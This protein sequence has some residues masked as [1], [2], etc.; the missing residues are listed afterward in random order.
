MAVF[1]VSAISHL[2]ISGATSRLPGFATLESPAELLDPLFARRALLA[3][4]LA[5]VIGGALGTTIVLRDLP[6]FTH[7]V[8]A[9]AYPTMVAAAA[10]GMSLA[11]AAQLGA[12]V[13]AALLWLLTRGSTADARQGDSRT[14]L[15]VAT[16]LAAGAV[17]AEVLAGSG[18][19]FARSPES[20]LFGSV[21]TV[22]KS[23]LVAAAATAAL[24]LP[25]VTLLSGRWLAVGFDPEAVGAMRISR[26][27]GVLLPL[28]AI[29][30]ASIL[31]L[32]GALMAGALMVIPAATARMLFDRTAMI[33]AAAVALAVVSGLFGLYLSLAFD[34]PAGASIAAVAGGL[35]ALAAIAVSV[36]SRAD[37]ISRPNRRDNHRTMAT[38]SLA[39]LVVLPALSGCGG[40]SGQT[41]AATGDANNDRVPV[42]ATTTHAADIVRQIGGNHVATTTMLK[43]G[44]DPHEF[45]PKPSDV[46]ALADARVIFRSGGAI[47]S[48]LQ[49]A[50]DAAGGGRGPIDLSDA[51]VLLPSDAA[52]GDSASNGESFNAHWFLDPVNLEAVGKRVRDEL[53]KADPATRETYRANAARYAQRTRAADTALARCAKRLSAKQRVIISDHNEFDYLAARYEFKVAARLQPASGGEPSVADLQRAV[54]AARASGAGAVVTSAGESGKVA[55]AVANRLRVPLL[56]LYG[57]SLAPGDGGGPHTSLDAIEFNL[58]RIAA[59]VSSGAVRCKT[60]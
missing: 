6:F 19:G 10:L 28:V 32:T 46:A 31:P 41:T 37:R 34:L 21:L 58:D 39:A 53:T 50:I 3:V 9:G 43:P 47:D 36:R 29:A 30:S 44:A 22:G 25:L 51:A 54:A 13:F 45:E 35:F 23:E 11:I 1:V 15:L 55:R 7:A 5:A 56:E 57:D 60:G 49:P 4:L 18:S 8:G 12:L 33:T 48:W 24:C 2:G 42:T 38:A 17:L 16:A 40:S 52:A 26:Y 20:M 14:G 27:D 59:A